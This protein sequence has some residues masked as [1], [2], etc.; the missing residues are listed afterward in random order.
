MSTSSKDLRT[1]ARS[2]AVICLSAGSSLIRLLVLSMLMLLLP[3]A[4][5]DTARDAE[6]PS[7]T[8]EQKIIN[9]SPPENAP[10]G[11]VKV[12]KLLPGT[13]G[14][15]IGTGSGL[16]LTPDWVLTAAHVV[17]NANPSD[18]RVA[19]D[20]NRL[21]KVR[22]IRLHPLYRNQNVGAGVL[23]GGVVDRR[24]GSIDV[25]LF[26]TSRHSGHQRRRPR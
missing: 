17:N 19:F 25:A 4:C 7:A 22:E 3:T 11:I 13:L 10:P 24:V 15:S 20:S 2:T 23:V 26:R 18:V 16:L 21:F 6:Q 1:K 12:D 5:A 8:V 9:G 14:T